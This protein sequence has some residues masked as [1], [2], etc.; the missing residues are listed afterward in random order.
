MAGGQPG[1]WEP[2]VGLLAGG[3]AGMRDGIGCRLGLGVG[4]A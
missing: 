4:E 2:A 3:M 1:L